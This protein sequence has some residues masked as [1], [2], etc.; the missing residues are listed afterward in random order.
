MRRRHPWAEFFCWVG[1]HVRFIEGF[2]V[3]LGRTDRPRTQFKQCACGKRQ[4][5]RKPKK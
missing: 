3:D 2:A 1:V 5:F 4:K